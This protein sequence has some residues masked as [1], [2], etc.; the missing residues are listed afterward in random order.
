MRGQILSKNERAE[1]RL[2]VMGQVFSRADSAL[3]GRRVTCKVVPAAKTSINE[4]PAWTTDGRDITINESRRSTSKFNTNQGLVVANGLNYH[5]LS[6][7]MFTPR[8]GNP[9]FAAVSREGWATAFNILEDQRIEGIMTTRFTTTRHYLTATVA[10]YFLNPEVPFRQTKEDVQSQSW[11]VIYGR[12]YLPANMRDHFRSVA[13]D[14]AQNDPSYAWSPSDLRKFESL[15]DRYIKLRFGAIIGEGITATAIS[16]IRDFNKLLLKNKHSNGDQVQPPNPFEH[17][18]PAVGNSSDKDQSAPGGETQ[19]VK[20]T[21]SGSEDGKDGDK[22]DADGKGK[23]KGGDGKGD[24]SDSDSGDSKGKGDS[25]SGGTSAGDSTA[26]GDGLDGALERALHDVA[27]DARVR[28]E[29]QSQS[30]VINT[31]GNK[32][33][34]VLDTVISRQMRPFETNMRSAKKFSKQLQQLVADT[35][36]GFV[37]H[38]DSGKLNIMR[39]V[40]G[41]SLDTVFDQWKGGKQDAESIEMVVLLDT[42]GSMSNIMTDACAAAWTLKSAI[43]S[44]GANARC[45]VITFGGRFGYLYRPNESANS[46]MRVVSSS[47]GTPVRRAI[48]EARSIFGM[49]ERRKKILVS[50]SDGVWSAVDGDMSYRIEELGKAGVTTAALFLCSEAHWQAQVSR[51]R[52]DQRDDYIEVLRNKHQIFVQGDGPEEIVKLGKQLVKRAIRS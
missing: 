8:K 28:S 42:S 34:G 44:L 23:G 46:V 16:I 31:S 36:P 2:A 48:D 18:N 12:R 35:D 49:S 9:I 5:E 13:Y 6:H 40:Q 14:R 21:G 20:G 41:A 45:S 50:V 30:R 37:K 3:A 52:P 39:A 38:R 4:A 32:F 11:P 27:N 17:P 15:I 51:M 7:V 43:D 1:L 19:D 25:G 29:T 24:K 10:E 22:S 26:P 33:D 47:G